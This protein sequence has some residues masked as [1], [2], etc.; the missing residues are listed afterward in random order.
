MIIDGFHFWVANGGRESVIYCLATSAPAKHLWKKQGVNCLTLS[1][2][3][4]CQ[5]R[6]P[7]NV[8]CT[9]ELTRSLPEGPSEGLR[10]FSGL[11]ELPQST[12]RS[13]LVRVH[14]ILWL[15]GTRRLRP[16]TVYQAVLAVSRLRCCMQSREFLQRPPDQLQRFAPGHINH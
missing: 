15:L 6:I 16:P 10:L 13:H 8:R 4:S 5:C 11:V 3:T 14:R 7:R 2:W 1:I 12:T 9:Q